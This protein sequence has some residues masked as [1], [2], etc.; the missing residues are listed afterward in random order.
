M[1]RS[2][3][4]MWMATLFGGCAVVYAARTAMP[5]CALAIGSEFNW[6]KKQSVGNIHFDTH[7]CYK[8]PDPTASYVWRYQ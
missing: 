2:E 3:K 5:L 1:F 4:N 6:N 7:F 8:L